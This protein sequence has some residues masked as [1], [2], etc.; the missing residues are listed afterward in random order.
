MA[1]QIGLI[2][3]PHLIRVKDLAHAP[4]AVLRIDRDVD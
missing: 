1:C 2:C 4:T 3:A